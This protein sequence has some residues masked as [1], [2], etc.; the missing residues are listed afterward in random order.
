MNADK[1]LHNIYQEYMRL[2]Q[3]SDRALAQIDDEAFFR[4]TDPQGNSMAI[5]IKH[6]A[7][8]MR[9]RWRDFLTSDGEKPDR[10]RERE[11]MLEEMDTRAHLM[12][13]WEASWNILRNTLTSLQAADLEKEITIRGESHAVPEALHRQ[14]THY[15]Y[16]TGQIV[17]MA[18]SQAGDQWQSLSIPKGQSEQFNKNPQSYL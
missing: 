14:L 12:A 16:H 3:L 1:Y 13:R 6:I 18:R 17:Q 9:S 2:K 7:G 15:A 4:Q 5:L 10:Q 11:F 8:N